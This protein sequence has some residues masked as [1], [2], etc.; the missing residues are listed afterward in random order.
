MHQ[1]LSMYALAHTS[2]TS[3][4]AFLLTIG[5]LMLTLITNYPRFV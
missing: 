3:K 2:P 1:T 5:E 4:V